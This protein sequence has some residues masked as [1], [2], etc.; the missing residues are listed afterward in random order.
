ML[1]SRV[2]NHVLYNKVDVFGIN[3]RIINIYLIFREKPTS[4]LI[5]HLMSREPLGKDMFVNSVL[6]NWLAGQQ[7][8]IRKLGE[9]I[10]TQLGKQVVD[11]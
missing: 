10:S 9:F 7:D 11:R 8:D 1:L 6:S 2:H 3:V 5:K 4:E